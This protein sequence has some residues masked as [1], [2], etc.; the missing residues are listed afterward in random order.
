[1]R[2]GERSRLCYNVLLQLGLTVNKLG[3]VKF[4][5]GSVLACC[6]TYKLKK[7]TT[8]EEGLV[9]VWMVPVRKQQED[10]GLHPQTRI[11]PKIHTL[12]CS[13]SNEIE[14]SIGNAINIDKTS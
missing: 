10:D 2:C 11:F 5:L 4:T 8:T 3:G 7:K 14:K 13:D 1:M 9:S 6:Q 12:L